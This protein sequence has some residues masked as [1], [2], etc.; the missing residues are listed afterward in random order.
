MA[1]EM[2]GGSRIGAAAADGE[3]SGDF[4]MLSR[5]RFRE[6]IGELQA[7]GEIQ[8]RQQG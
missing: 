7:G 2:T 3:T 4:Q 8:V 5:G 1:K 6:A